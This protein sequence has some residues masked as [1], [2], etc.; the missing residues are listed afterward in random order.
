MQPLFFPFRL[1]PLASPCALILS[2]VLA[3]SCAL[4]L[5]LTTGGAWA[6]NSPD[7]EVLVKKLTAAEIRR[8]TTDKTWIIDY[9]NAQLTSTT[10]YKPGGE[11]FTERQ[12]VIERMEWFID[13]LENR[14]CVRTAFGSRCGYVVRFGST[15]KICMRL[16]PLGDCSYTVVRIEDGDTYGLEQRAPLPI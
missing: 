16:D 8:L 9:D 4:S 1:G 3:L 5:G 11:R 12:G 13:E 10:Y 15:I 7:E 6:L 2:L 14:R